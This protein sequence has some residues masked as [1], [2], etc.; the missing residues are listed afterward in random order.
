MRVAESLEVRKINTLVKDYGRAF[1]ENLNSGL[2]A[3]F[4]KY[5]TVSTETKSEAYYHTSDILTEMAFQ[6]PY[7]SIRIQE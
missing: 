1:F 7:A 5:P 6:N 4:L 2:S 3:Y